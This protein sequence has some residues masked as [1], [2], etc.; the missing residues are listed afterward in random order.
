MNL[1]LIDTLGAI[2][3]PTEVV[4]NPDGSQLLLLPY[5]G[6]VLGLFPPGSEENFFWIPSSSRTAQHCP[7]F[8]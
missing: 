5:G 8:L 6:R 3:K 1:Q 4:A 7:E 2:D